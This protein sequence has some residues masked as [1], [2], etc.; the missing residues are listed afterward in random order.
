[1]TALSASRKLLNGAQL[2]VGDSA[3]IEIERL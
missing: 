3:M 1:L 2:E